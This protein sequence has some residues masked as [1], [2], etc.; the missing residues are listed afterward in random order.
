MSTAG[1][2]DL[3]GVGPHPSPLQL[4]RDMPALWRGF[5]LDHKS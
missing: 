2:S 1:T 4:E 3:S 5:D